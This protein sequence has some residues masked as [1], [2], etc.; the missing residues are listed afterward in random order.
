MNTSY[1]L[2]TVVLVVHLTWI[3]WVIFGWVAAKTAHA[4]VVPFRFPD[5]RHFY[6]DCTLALP[7]DV[8][9]TV[10]RIEGRRDRVSR[11]IPGSLPGSSHISRCAR[12]TAGFRGGGRMD[13]QPVPPRK[14][15][16]TEVGCPTSCRTVS[17]RRQPRPVSPS[18]SAQV[19]LL[20]DEFLRCL[21]LRPRLLEGRTLPTMRQEIDASIQ[22]SVVA[23]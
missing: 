7:F 1:V 10:A 22:A 2:A 8:A 9:R 13:G 21:G 16:S 12:A 15:F 14:A 17:N 19:A 23:R 3:V 18:A 6:R 20:H 4:P 11:A 5:L